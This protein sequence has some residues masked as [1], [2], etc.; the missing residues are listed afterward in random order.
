M[1]NFLVALAFVAMVSCPA[2]VASL[3][4]YKLEDEA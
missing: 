2:F 3:P 4:F 1:H